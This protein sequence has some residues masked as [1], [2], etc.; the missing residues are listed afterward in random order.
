MIALTPQMGVLVAVAAADFRCG[1][2]G[3]V[4][5]CRTQL[6]AD[7]MRGTLFA[8]RNRRGSS[9]KLLVY[10]GQGFWLCQRR[11]SAGR[12]RYWPKSGE[13]TTALQAHELAVLLR[14]GDPGATQAAPTWHPVDVA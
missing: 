12:F 5:L 3:L 1:I 10:D 6:N 13:A 8:F 11:L 7:P 9:V 2:D 4:K 14:G